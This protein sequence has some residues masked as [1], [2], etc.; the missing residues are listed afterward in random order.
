MSIDLVKLRELLSKQWTRK[1]LGPTNVDMLLHALN[2]VENVS[3]RLEINL[4]L[5]TGLR[6]GS[7]I[8]TY[9]TLDGK[10]IICNAPIQDAFT[11]LRHFREQHGNLLLKIL[12]KLKINIPPPSTTQ[13]EK[14]QVTILQYM[15]PTST[16]TTKQQANTKK[17]EK[18]R[19]EKKE[20][21]KT[22]KR[23]SRK[24]RKRKK[25][26]NSKKK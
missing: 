23:K 9:Y 24:K 25:T 21:K 14:K 17:Q 18:T 2:I 22:T 11:A 19:E 4:D 15:T 26:S 5:D 1:A 13:E 20:Q 6:V 7:Y 12:Q 10:C 16:Q 3:G 8:M